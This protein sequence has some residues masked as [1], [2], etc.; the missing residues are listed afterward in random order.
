MFDSTHRDRIEI[1]KSLANCRCSADRSARKFS[2]S[3]RS[4]IAS[5][6]AIA[7]LGLPAKVGALVKTE[8]EIDICRRIGLWG[9]TI[10]VGVNDKV[11]TGGRTGA[12]IIDRCRALTNR[13]KEHGLHTCLMGMD[14]T[15]TRP[16]FLEK[17]VRTLDPYLDEYTI[18]ELPGCGLAVGHAIPC[19]PCTRMDQQA[20]SKFILTIIPQ[21]QQAWQLGHSSEEFLD[22][23]YDSKWRGGV[24]GSLRVGGICSGSGIRSGVSTRIDSP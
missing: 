17:V 13:A 24:H 4:E 7:S 9:V 8:D 2:P 1:A 23:S 16:E 12:D 15:R 21:L 19:N 3:T 18:S 6:E 14:A 10:L 20:P 11:L 5:A 22:R